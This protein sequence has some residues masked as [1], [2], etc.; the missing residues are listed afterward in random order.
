MEKAQMPAYLMH[1][2]SKLILKLCFQA[3]DSSPRPSME[4]EPASGGGDPS[5]WEVVLEMN[6]LAGPQRG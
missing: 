5:K 2:H 6:V 1:Q 3:D 4:M